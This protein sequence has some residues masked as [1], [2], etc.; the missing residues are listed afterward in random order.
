MPRKRIEINTMLYFELVLVLW[1]LLS[2]RLLSPIAW[3]EI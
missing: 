2:S 3:D 1:V